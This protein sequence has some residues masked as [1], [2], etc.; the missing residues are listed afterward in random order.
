MRGTG[1]CVTRTAAEGPKGG[2]EV[3]GPS[4]TKTEFRRPSLIFKEMERPCLRSHGFAGD[5]KNLEAT[6]SLWERGW[7]TKRGT[8]AAVV[9]NRAPPA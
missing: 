5:S 1:T 4:G 6:K 7:Q 3:N 9:S 2:G 8:R